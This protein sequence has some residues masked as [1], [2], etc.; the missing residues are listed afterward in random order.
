MF[1]TGNVDV[2]TGWRGWL[3]V[4]RDEIRGFPLGM[5]IEEALAERDH[6]QRV[7]EDAGYTA[8]CQWGWFIFSDGSD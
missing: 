4:D 2:T 3:R 6:R 5:C 1:G 8:S 7:V